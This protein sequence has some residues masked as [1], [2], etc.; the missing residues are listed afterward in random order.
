MRMKQRFLPLLR[1][2][3][4]FIA[5]FTAFTC[6][7]EKI[8]NT[9]Y[10]FCVMDDA[11]ITDYDEVQADNDNRIPYFTSGH[12]Y[13]DYGVMIQGNKTFLETQNHVSTMSVLMTKP[14]DGANPGLT[15][16]WDIGYNG[17]AYEQ[18][19]RI[20][21]KVQAPSGVSLEN[22]PAKALI[23]DEI[24]F[25]TKL[26]GTFPSFSG[27]GYFSYYY[28]SSDENVATVS[29]STV[30]VSAGRI[31]A[32]NPGTATIKVKVYAEN[33]KY[34]GSYYIGTATAEIEV[35]DNL[36]PTDISLSSRELSLDIGQQETLTATLTPED[37]RTD[38]TWS[39]SDESVATVEDGLVKAVGRGNTSIEART[40]NGLSAKC[41]VTV[42]GDQDYS[43]VCIDGLYYDLDRKEHTAAVVHENP[44][45]PNYSYISGEIVIPEKIQC[46][47]ADY[48]V[49]KIDKYAFLDC[50]II[51]AK[52]PKSITS[53]GHWAF[54]QSHLE[55]IT[56]PDGLKEIGELAF[57][58]TKLESIIIGP[59]V[60]LIGDGAFADCRDLKAVYVDDGNPYFVIYKYCL[61]NAAKTRLYYVPINNSTVSFP[62]SLETIGA[63]A[64]YSNQAVS[65]IQ[66]P[67]SLITIEHHAFEN[68]VNIES[69]SFPN[70][71]ME[72]GDFA[73]QFCDNLKEI[74]F[75]NK[76]KM[77]GENAFMTLNQ[78]RLKVV[79]ISA[80]NP[81][82]ADHYYVFYNRY[83][84]TLVV[85]LGR[86]STYKKDSVWGKF[87]TITDDE[88]D[89]ALGVESL[90]DND[91]AKTHPDVYDLN[92][93]LLI[94]GATEEEIRSLPAGVYLIGDKKIVI[95]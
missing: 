72:I 51:S 23:G 73:F 8:D 95:R 43:G 40:S 60:S 66:F 85:P 12:W 45:E 57:R 34:S 89:P 39:S 6:G 52:L 9:H 42:L 76:L 35:V 36:D 4:V 79:R 15:H 27:Y 22:I 11:E 16:Y 86:V 5:A 3:S 10:R 92:G 82:T 14:Y 94:Q 65:S 44:N 84:A 25:K 71:L 50:E 20:Y 18:T 88:N 47:G 41:Y 74:V 7:A 64:C 54:L 29:G 93:V 2:L 59:N 17:V 33:S 62:D 67:E 87:A 31:T 56:L 21:I 77:I 68:C 83:E 70:S 26:N 55:N 53:I 75:G 61:Y 30:T 91:I 24:P 1:S 13:S 32:I 80:L 38:I 48:T 46:Y 28:S 19:T 63:Y 90:R 58:Q 78:N 69:L 81:P 49:T 37:A